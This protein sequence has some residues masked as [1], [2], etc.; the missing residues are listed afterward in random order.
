VN[1]LESKKIAT[2][3]LFG[4]N[5][6]KQPAYKDLNYRA[7][8]RLDNTDLVMNNLF[9]IGAYPGLNPRMLIY[10]EKVLNNFLREVL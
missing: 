9:W 7:A 4:G 5:L 1:Y 8:G 3:M 2:R 6:I 10:I